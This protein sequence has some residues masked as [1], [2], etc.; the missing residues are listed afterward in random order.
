MLLEEVAVRLI[1]DSERK[2]FDE[3]LANKH[4]LNNVLVGWMQT[5]DTAPLRVVHMDGKAV[6][7]AQPAPPRSQA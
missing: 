6:K 4:Y 7:N 2:R 5:Q 1:E 3:E